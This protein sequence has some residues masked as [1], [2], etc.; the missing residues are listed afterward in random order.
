M[1]EDDQ[2]GE[3][4]LRGQG[5]RGQDALQPGEGGVRETQAGYSGQDE[6]GENGVV[7]LIIHRTYIG[8]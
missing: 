5:H 7:M 3:A 2:G 6:Q 8:D 4:A 1:A